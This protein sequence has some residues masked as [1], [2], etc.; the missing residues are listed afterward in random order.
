MST[1]GNKADNYAIVHFV[2]H[3]CQH[4]TI[5]QIHSSGDAVAKI[6]EISGEWKYVQKTWRVSLSIGVRTTMIR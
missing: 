3:A 5:D 4:I 1:F 6:L 2:P